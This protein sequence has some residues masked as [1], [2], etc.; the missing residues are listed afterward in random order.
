[1]GENI[2]DKQHDCFYHIEKLIDLRL[3]VPFWRCTKCNKFWLNH[4]V[5]YEIAKRGEKPPGYSPQR[6]PSEE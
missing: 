3:D 6:W 1:M 2:N 4:T 5:E